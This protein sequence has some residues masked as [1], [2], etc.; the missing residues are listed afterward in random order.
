MHRG[1]G[2]LTDDRHRRSRTKDT[3]GLEMRRRGL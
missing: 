2:F 3:D 1:A